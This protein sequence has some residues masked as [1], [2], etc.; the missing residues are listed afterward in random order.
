[1]ATLTSCNFEEKS[2]KLHVSRAGIILKSRDP[3]IKM[4]IIT[5]KTGFYVQYS[6]MALKSP[7]LQQY[8]GSANQN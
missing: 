1:M 5:T 7:F 6:K 4:T 3:L 8:A 2:L